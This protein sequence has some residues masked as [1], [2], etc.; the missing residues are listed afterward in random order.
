MESETRSEERAADGASAGIAFA[1]ISGGQILALP[2]R[3]PSLIGDEEALRRAADQGGYIRRDWAFSSP[4]AIAWEGD[5]P[6]SWSA[7]AGIRIAAIAVA[8]RC[9]ARA[10]EQITYLWNPNQRPSGDS[11]PSGR[12]LNVPWLRGVQQHPGGYAESDY[13]DKNGKRI[14]FATPLIYSGGWS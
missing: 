8:H 5:G 2:Y 14:A 11:D 9:G 3:P 1:N 7:N 13:R 6:S 4:G 10:I 12:P